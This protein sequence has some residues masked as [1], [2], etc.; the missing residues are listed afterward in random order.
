MRRVHITRGP[1]RSHGETAAMWDDKEE[2]NAL[3]ASRRTLVFGWKSSNEGFPWAKTVGLGNWELRVGI[4][5]YDVTAVFPVHGKSGGS[6]NAGRSRLLFPRC[7]GAR[8][9]PTAAREWYVN[10]GAMSLSF[11]AG[12]LFSAHFGG[13]RCGLRGEFTFVASTSL[14]LFPR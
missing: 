14:V 4:A 6:L 2:W 5:K 8:L 7:N 3:G 10:L 13:T 12:Y 11:Y 1:G 9:K